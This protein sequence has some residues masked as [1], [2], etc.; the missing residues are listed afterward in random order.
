VTSPL[1]MLNGADLSDTAKLCW[2]EIARFAGARS[3]CWP[4]QATLCKI[5]GWSA[6]KLQ[7][8]LVELRDAEVLRIKQRGRGQTPVYYLGNPRVIEEKS[9]ENRV[10]AAQL[11]FDFAGLAS[12]TVCEDI[13]EVPSEFKTTTELCLSVEEAE[14]SRS[15][16]A[17]LKS[18]PDNETQATSETAAEFLEFIRVEMAFPVRGEMPDAATVERV[19]ALLADR[20]GYRAFRVRWRAWCARN[21][22]EGW[23]I[24][25]RLAEDC[26]RD[27]VSFAN[28]GR[29]HGAQGDPGTAFL[30][31]HATP[32]LPLAE[33]AQLQR[34]KR[35][36]A[37]RSP[38]VDP[39]VLTAVQAASRWRG[40]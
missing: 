24:F 22:P 26:A 23:G 37:G 31:V 33:F 21:T 28:G 38:T 8:V 40:G 10:D 1:A 36:P 20:E 9:V 2:T 19:A 5:L 11:A 27:P 14:N 15:A 3:Y 32:R 25:V 18:N 34:V 13:Y 4:S 35:M 30:N 16:S 29:R 39:R 7:Y 12:Q 17:S 6:R